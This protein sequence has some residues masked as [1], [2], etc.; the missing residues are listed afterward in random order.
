MKIQQIGRLCFD[1]AVIERGE[2]RVLNNRIAWNSTS[3]EDNAVFLDI[4]AWNKNA[5][6]ISK[7]YKKGYEIL[8]EGDL[9][10]KTVKKDNVDFQSVAFQISRV[11]FTNGNPKEIR[12]ITND[13][14]LTNEEDYNFL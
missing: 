14:F 4:V 1:V 11:I 5:D 2:S 7:Y 8:L 10:N 3:K 12:E 6:I 13:D 9:I